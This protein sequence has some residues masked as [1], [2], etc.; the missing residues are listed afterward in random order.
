MYEFFL[1]R[2]IFF[3]YTYG[4]QSIFLH[5]YITYLTTGMIKYGRRDI[6]L[7]VLVESRG[8]KNASD[9]FCTTLSLQLSFAVTI[10]CFVLVSL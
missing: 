4:Q 3:M 1:V 9:H 6:G 5:Q 7:V 10:A 2:F 8:N